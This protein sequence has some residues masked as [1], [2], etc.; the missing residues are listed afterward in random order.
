MNKAE[1]TAK[2]LKGPHPWYGTANPRFFSRKKSKPAEI[3]IL[4]DE[5]KKQL[6][7]FP[8]WAENREVRMN[9]SQ[10]QQALNG[11]FMQPGE[12]ALRIELSITALKATY[13]QSFLST[14]LELIVSP[15]QISLT[16]ALSLSPLVSANDIEVESTDNEKQTDGAAEVEVINF[17]LV[18]E[19]EDFTAWEQNIAID[20]EGHAIIED[21]EGIKVR[22]TFQKIVPMS[23]LDF[24]PDDSANSTTR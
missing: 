16:K 5:Q 10:L 13:P 6:W 12:E 7:P 3:L 17:K 1:L 4:T 19:D 8:S 21:I 18:N 22:L 9:R 2:I 23:A 14:P 20:E 11:N 24:Q 15:I